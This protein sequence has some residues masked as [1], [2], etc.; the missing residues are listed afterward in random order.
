MKKEFKTLS[1]GKLP[2][3]EL[4]KK[5]IDLIYNNGESIMKKEFNLSEKL[6]YRTIESAAIKDIKEFIKEEGRLLDAVQ[7]GYITWGEFKCERDK[8]A[9]KD[10]I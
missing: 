10:L 2:T 1:K 8:L 7:K 3:K 5:E 4:T 6:R 9:G